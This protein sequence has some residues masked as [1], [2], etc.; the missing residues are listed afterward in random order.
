M[1]ELIFLWTLI[2]SHPT[3]F[4]KRRN[5]WRSGDSNDSMSRLKSAR[6]WRTTEK[7][8]FE[9]TVALIT[10]GFNRIK[11]NLIKIKV[12]RITTSDNSFETPGFLLVR[13]RC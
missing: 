11:L 6:T 4:F 3:I 7:D 2:S 9:V 5:C 10:I 8:L 13:S 12:K 1:P